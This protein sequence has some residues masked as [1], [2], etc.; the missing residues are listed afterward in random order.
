MTAAKARR[1]GPSR[2]ANAREFIEEFYPKLR[3]VAP[4]LDMDFSWTDK[5][6]LLHDMSIP[7]AIRRGVL[8]TEKEIE[9]G[10]FVINGDFERR[11]AK[12]LE[13]R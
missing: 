7:T 5:A 12:F 11:V 10:V 1:I 4:Q 13:G 2:P 6:V 8:Y 9:D 3:Q